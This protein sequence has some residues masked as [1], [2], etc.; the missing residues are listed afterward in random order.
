MLEGGGV[1]RLIY[2]FQAVR[3]A[4]GRILSGVLIRKVRVR[5]NETKLAKLS[6]GN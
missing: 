4:E 3:N 6:A 1:N 2:I 5:T